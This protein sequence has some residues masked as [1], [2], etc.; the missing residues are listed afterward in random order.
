[1]TTKYLPKG[2]SPKVCKCRVVV[3][4]VWGLNESNGQNECRPYDCEG[5]GL[6]SPGKKTSGIGAPHSCKAIA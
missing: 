6:T 1:M 4:M 2:I 3:Y 5:E